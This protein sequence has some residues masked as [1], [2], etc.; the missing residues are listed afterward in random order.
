MIKVNLIY[1]EM[2]GVYFYFYFM[3]N[4]YFFCIIFLFFML[5]NIEINLGLNNNIFFMKFFSIVYNNVCSFLF[6]LDIIIVELLMYDII[7]I[8]EIYFDDFINNESI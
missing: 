7:I 1:I 6:K 3:R 4:L 8:S 5:G 2:I